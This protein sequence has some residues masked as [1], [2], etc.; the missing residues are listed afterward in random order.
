LL[1]RRARTGSGF[2]I[3]TLV[4]LFVVTWFDEW[5]HP[6][7]VGRVL[8][9]WDRITQVGPDSLALPIV[10]IA[11]L[12]LFGELVAWLLATAPSLRRRAGVAT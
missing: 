11:Q 8:G 4:T 7:L 6:P 5:T 9:W 12:L 10:V 3:L 1:Y 2:A